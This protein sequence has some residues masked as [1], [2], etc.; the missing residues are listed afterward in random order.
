M[1]ERSRRKWRS[2]VYKGALS[3][4][5]CSHSPAKSRV[6]NRARNHQIWYLTT[7]FCFIN[8]YPACRSTKPTVSLVGLTRFLENEGSTIEAFYCIFSCAREPKVRLSYKRPVETCF[9]EAPS[10]RNRDG[11]TCD[12]Y[13]VLKIRTII[14]GLLGNTGC[15]SANTNVYIIHH[16]LIVFIP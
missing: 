8:L 6:S 12:S 15:N 7:R 1:E 10:S 4:H 2:N 16:W 9:S 13:Y 5:L 3:G 11:M 14:C